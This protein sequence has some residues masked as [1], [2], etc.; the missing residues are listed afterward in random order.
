MHDKWDEN[1][2]WNL[3]LN[4]EQAIDQAIDHQIIL[5]PESAVPVATN[6]IKNWLS[7]LSVLAND[8][9]STILM[10][11]IKYSKKTNQY[12]NT[13]L[14]LGNATGAY[15]KK[16]LVPFGEYIPNIFKPVTN[17]LGI[18][19]P[20]LISGDL[21][22]KNL[23]V[24]N[25]DLASFICYEIAFDNIIRQ[26]LPQ[27]EFIVTITDSGWFGNSLAGYQLQQMSQIRSLQTNRFQLLANNDG[28]SS[29]IDSSGN[30]MT[31]LPR[32]QAGILTGTIFPNQTITIWS[33][34]GNLPIE[35]IILCILFFAI[36]IKRRYARFFVK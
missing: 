14:A 17:M 10:G 23:R 20:G 9:E 1:Y 16:Q 21:H 5:L 11:A 13:L 25:K 35:I 7:N 19:D 28:L 36:Y 33:K 30:I 15:Y 29:V 27:G 31:D 6:H 3:L 32:H 34:L 8:K 26:Q 24:D 12:F 4:Y 22:Q 2:F 18:P